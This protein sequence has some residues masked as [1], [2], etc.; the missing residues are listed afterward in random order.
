MVKAKRIARRQIAFKRGKK[1]G[2][3]LEDG[4]VDEVAEGAVS[5]DALHSRGV[6]AAQEDDAIAGESAVLGAEVGGLVEGQDKGVE[7]V[8]EDHI[9]EP[10]RRLAVVRVPDCS[11]RLAVET[12]AAEEQGRLNDRLTIMGRE[13]K[14][15]DS[16]KWSIH[17]KKGTA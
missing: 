8:G 2:I 11:R 9:D 10:R 15:A 1:G 3:C 6:R 4:G 5:D 12:V 16:A 17:R 13:L 14:K 7:Q